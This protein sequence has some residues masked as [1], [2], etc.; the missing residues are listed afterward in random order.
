MHRTI[1]IATTCCLLGLPALAKSP[2]YAAGLAELRIAANAEASQPALDGYVWYPTSAPGASFRFGANAV[3]EGFEAHPG[4]PL[5]DGLFPLV[6][7]SHGLTGNVFNQGWL[8]SDL[9]AHGMIVA[10]VD[11]PGTA[12]RDRRP[13][14]RAR[15][16]RRPQDLSRVID[17]VL[18]DPTIAAS[19]DAER[20]AAA[21]HSLGGFTVL[22]LAGAGLDPARHAAYCSAHPERA[23]CVFL[24][25]IDSRGDADW[26][27]RMLATP[28]GDPRVDAVVSF[29]LGLTQLFDPASLAG[30]DLPVLVIGAGRENAVPLDAESRALAA[31]LPNAT[32][33]E[34]DD[35]GHYDFL[36]AC[37]P[38]GEAVLAELE[39]GEEFVCGAGPGRSREALHRTIAAE[40]RAFLA[41]QAFGPLG[42]D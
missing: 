2:P 23:D 4:S 6:V 14:E 11:H 24:A 31:A 25:T 9:A 35:L 22:A 36:G 27:Q 41:D 3:F 42:D 38:N 16:W 1:A 26:R 40:V 15:L 12:T 32:Y 19:V 29:D 30:L 20:I 21:G 39:P 34:L 8:A 28:T 18:A 10:A 13:E 37:R 33:L 5:A 17:A 7:L